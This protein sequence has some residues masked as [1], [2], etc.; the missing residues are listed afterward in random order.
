MIV[1]RISKEKFHKDISGTGSRI[2]GGRWNYKGFPTLY[3][4][5]TR[6]LSTLEL[7]V[8][9]DND[10]L[11]P[12][13]KLLSV[14]LPL[15]AEEI[16]SIQIRDLPKKWR[17]SP[18]SELLKLI[19]KKNLIDQ[20]RLAIKVPSVIIPDE[21]NIVINPLHEGFKDVKIKRIEDYKIDIR[22][23]K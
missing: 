1:F 22:L 9:T 19:G 18:P 17:K 11:P 6:A 21:Y 5:E 12:N 13:L 10:L 3:T 16:M 4:S 7:L 14:E 20:N 23:L 8:H 2:Y 15:I